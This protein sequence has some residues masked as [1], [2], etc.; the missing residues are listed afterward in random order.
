M[1]QGGRFM[2]LSATDAE[3]IQQA[4][5][6]IL[7]RIGMAQAPPQVVKLVCDAGGAVSDGGR[8]LFPESLIDDCLHALPREVTLCGQAERHDL[9]LAGNQ[10]HVGTGGAA[11][12]IVDIDTGNYR[13]SSLQDLHQAARLADALPHVHFFSRSLVARDM[14]TAE[15]LEVNTAFACLAGTAKHVCVS[16]SSPR[17]VELIASMCHMVAGSKEAFLRRPFLSLNVNHAVPPLRFDADACDVLLKA[18]EV[19][20]PV[21]VNTFG[22]MGASSPVTVAGC[23]AQTIAETTAGMVIGWLADPSA[24]LVFGPRPM[25][26][27][28][29]TGGMSGGSGEQALLTAASI[30]MARHLGLPNSTI[31]GASDSKIADA[32][33]GYEKALNVT[34][35]AQAGCNFI[36][37]ACGMQAGLMAASL[38]SY[39]IDNDMLG[40]VLKSLSPV[41]VSDATLALDSIASVVSG[42]GHFL[43]QPDTLARMSSDFLYP[44]LADRQPPAAWERAGAEDI[45]KVA[46]RRAKQLLASHFPAH[47]DS[48]LQARL[49]DAFDIRLPAEAMRAP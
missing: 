20:I 13:D 9:V 11:P 2:P 32:Q 15:A 10:V 4:A 30:Q 36:T 47:L 25:I 31:A 42:E 18:V 26:T 33:A 46:I 35:A 19:G 8:L 37:Q 29:R 16:A 39:V 22:Q 1:A 21:M 27:D 23:V 7:A 3:T 24:R 43:G 38:E 5:F 41:E 6:D 34:L 48:G 17:H 14:P 45:R 28:L 49:R 40:S 44:Q 12:S